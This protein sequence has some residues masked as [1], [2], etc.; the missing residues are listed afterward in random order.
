MSVH[1]AYKVGRVVGIVQDRKVDL[2]FAV[3]VSF[4]LKTTGGWVF[5]GARA[6][7]THKAAWVTMYARRQRQF[8]ALNRR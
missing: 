8:V 1:S 3:P 4:S 7:D 5:C 2:A 6:G